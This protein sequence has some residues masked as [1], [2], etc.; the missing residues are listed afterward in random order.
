MIAFIGGLS[1]IGFVT[2][3]VLGIIALIKNRSKAKKRF[4]ISG[5]LFVLMIIFIAISPTP[6]NSPTTTPVAEAEQTNTDKVETA[7]EPVKTAQAS[8][9]ENKTD[10]DQQKEKDKVAAEL[11]QN[12]AKKKADEEKAAAK[13]AADK[14]KAIKINNQ[15][16]VKAFEKEFYAIEDQGD[17]VFDNYQS[18][19]TGLGNGTSDVFTAYSA[20]TD[21]KAMAK[22][23]ASEY[24][25]MKAPDGL[26]EDVSKSL[27]EA[28]MQAFYAYSTKADAFDNVLEFLDD[29][30]PS[31]LQEFKDNMAMSDQQVL[32]GAFKLLEA[33]EQVGL[34]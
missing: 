29:Q 16:I 19:L 21:A 2:F 28:A 22:S 23:L 24:Y 5:S 33:K 10:E 6:P 25:S 15:K 32:Q 31:M 26:P 11:A 4:I 13:A 9:T 18:V 34:K 30:K 1:T 20:T 17:S 7:S 12:E 14:A 8:D 27:R 3:F